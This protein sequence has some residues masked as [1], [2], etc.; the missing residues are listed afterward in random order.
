MIA[1]LKP[2]PAYKGS[3]IEWMGQVPSGWGLRRAK[4]LF[5]KMAR[6]IRP[7][8]EIVTC[9]RDGT[10][11]LRRNRRLDGFTEAIQESGYQG[12][13]CGDLVIHQMD[14]FA[15]A[16]GVS[17]SD[18]KGSPVY[19]VCVP[20]SGVH[21]HYHQRVVRQM[22]LSGWI[23]A[24][25]KGVRER[26]TDFRFDIFGR[27]VLPLPALDEQA[28]IVRFLDHVDSRIQRFIA[29][30]ERL[31]ELLE[32]EKQAII[33]RAV[34]RGLDP[35]VPLKPSGV[36]WLGDVPVH[37][38]A[39][40]M[41]NV[42]ELRVSN[43]DKHVLPDE[44]PVRLCNYVD[45]YR[46]DRITSAF[47]FMPGSAS[48]REAEHFGLRHEDVVLTKD[49]ESWEDIASPAVVIDP[50]SDLVCGYHL[51]ILR[52]LPSALAGRYLA[53][54]LQAGP[55]ATQLRVAAN[56]VTRYGLTQGAIRNVWIPL[57]DLAEQVAIAGFV[58]QAKAS[59][60]QTRV[61]AERQICLLR[62]Y[63]TRLIS[64]VV[65]GKLDV[66][67][68]AERLP[69]DTEAHDTALDERLEEAATA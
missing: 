54:A 38:E 69:G 20:A 6:P 47:E 62:E 22:A 51:A 37:W 28:A 46:H 56:G 60:D 45:V 48:C 24:L 15:G 9:F 30:K 66:R 34:T 65:T 52:P 58:D 19:A 39:C 43:V 3:G 35:H 68:A 40:R 16:V 31:I 63:R 33:D 53:S 12:I 26:S 10:V 14:A 8:D 25:A 42:A 17:D 64:D 13:R 29:A 32:E 7:T 5:R 11:T 18:G 50:P 67:E 1:D 23:G 44:V 59:I 21:P 2:Y 36:D 27:Q 61:T 4:H 49:S 57:P 55:V 41:A